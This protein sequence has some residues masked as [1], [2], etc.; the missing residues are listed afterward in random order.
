MHFFNHLSAVR[1]SGL[2]ERCVR[3]TDRQDD[4]GV[5]T[6]LSRGNQRR[7]EIDKHA[8]VH[9]ASPR[10]QDTSGGQQFITQSLTTTRHQFCP[11]YSFIC[12]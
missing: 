6:S 3:I 2:P 8:T 5:G 11:T 7:H 9:G 10:P 1:A 12:L 4:P